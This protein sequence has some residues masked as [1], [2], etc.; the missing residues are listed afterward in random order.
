M[1]RVVQVSEL[2]GIC[3]PKPPQNSSNPP[4]S[5]HASVFSSPPVWSLVPGRLELCRTEC[6]SAM[7]WN[8]P[9][10]RTFKHS[11]LFSPSLSLH[12][13]PSFSLLLPLSVSIC[14][15]PLCSIHFL[16]P[17]LI[18]SHSLPQSLATRLIPSL[19]SLLFLSLYPFSLS[20]ILSPCLSP[21]L[22]PFPVIYFLVEHSLS[23]VC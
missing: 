9:S 14:L 15:S 19:C 21:S 17:S 2:C 10:G 1:G 20:H 12:L 7:F 4:P 5:P 16:C 22:L 3:L 23:S 8:L 13:S 6:P 18:F 11:G